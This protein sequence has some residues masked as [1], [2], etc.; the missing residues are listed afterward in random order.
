MQHILMTWNGHNINDGTVYEAWIPVGQLVNLTA[1]GVSVPRATDFPFI[2][3]TMLPEHFFSFG[4]KIAPVAVQ[5][6][7][8]PQYRE[9][10]KGWF[11]VTDKQRHNLIVRNPLDTD[12]QWY[13]T[14]F[15]V[16]LIE[17]SAGIY[18]I[19]LQVEMPVWRVVT[20]LTDTWNIAASGVT[21]S[22]TNIGNV[23]VPP[24][25]ELTPTAANPDRLSYSRWIAITNNITTGFN[26]PFDIVN[27]S[28]DTAALVAGGKCQADGDDLLVWMDG[29]L[30]DR[31]L[32]GM[33]TA[34]TRVWINLSLS[35][36]QAATTEV[37][38]AGAGAISTIT[39]SK[40]RANKSFLEA[41]A[42]AINKV[43]MIGNEAFTFTGVNT[44]LWQLTGVTRA[45]KGTSMAAHLHPATLTWVEHDLYILYGDSGLSAP[46]VNDD[47]KP[48]LDLSSSNSSWTFTNFYDDTSARSAMWRGERLASKTNLSYVFTGNENSYANPSTRL[49]MALVGSNSEFDSFSAI[50]ETGTLQWILYHPAGFTNVLYSGEK[51]AADIAVFPA[52]AGAQVLEG[53]AAW[54]TKYTE[55]TPL[56]AAVWEAFGPRSVALGGTYTNLRFALDGT[57][58]AVVNNLALI[59]FNTVTLTIDSTYLPSISIRAETA[60]NFFESRLTNNTTGEFIEFS[61]PC[62]LNTALTID[63]E[64]KKAYLADGGRVNVLLSSNR[65]EWLSLQESA[66]NTLQWDDAG[67]AGITFV[68]T[69]RDR[70]L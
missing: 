37:D 60:I 45:C 22:I 23:R 56:V 12:R 14:G 44:A 42:R 3:T 34:S 9:Q 35:P 61:A 39:L 53:N 8:I 64:A 24:K 41:M 58:N 21:R 30:V 67:T 25:Y 17:N 55:A 65:T 18:T 59:Q 13:L 10:L 57:I 63:C 29:G 48:I 2:S 31:W 16:R 1:R 69:H 40:T 11:N 27:G 19:T 5:N 26:A 28:L 68:T 38:I 32:Y 7:Q 47:Y 52:V 54:V 4:V 51:Y 6:N 62:P 20:P 33:N 36:G 66:A 49:G 46:D 43:V 15:P 50:G 70:N